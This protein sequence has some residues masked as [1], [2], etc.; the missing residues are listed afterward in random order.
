MTD[1]EY[2]ENDTFGS[3]HALSVA[4]KTMKERCQQLQTRLAT[5]EEEN[6]CLRLKC[7][8]D[9]STAILKIN[10]NSQKSTLQI[11]QVCKI[12]LYDYYCERM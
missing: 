8:K 1:V 7:G 10:N 6:V 3:Y 2:M 4:F 5:V 11:L 9:T 12:K